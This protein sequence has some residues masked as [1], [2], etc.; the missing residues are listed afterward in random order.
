MNYSFCIIRF[1]FIT[2]HWSKINTNSVF[3]FISLHS[4]LREHHFTS[5][6]LYVSPWPHFPV[7]LLFILQS[8]LFLSLSMF[9][10]NLVWEA[11]LNAFWQPLLINKAIDSLN[12]SL[13]WDSTH[14]HAQFVLHT[15]T[16]ISP[17]NFIYCTAAITPT[18]THTHTPLET[19]LDLIR[20]YPYTKKYSLCVCFTANHVWPHCWLKAILS[21]N[22]SFMPW[23]LACKSLTQVTV[24]Q[25][26]KEAS[27]FFDFLTGRGCNSLSWWRIYIHIQVEHC[28][29]S[30]VRGEYSTELYCFLLRPLLKLN[31]KK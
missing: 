9:H 30:C 28:W 14:T 11:W 1:P 6:T 3:S 15:F 4:F 2:G 7:F 25:G 22:S 16:G 20:W 13:R 27:L 23:R 24:Y 31:G 12:A 5:L 18:H 19:L 8:S 26:G 17:F 21:S 10:S 29:A